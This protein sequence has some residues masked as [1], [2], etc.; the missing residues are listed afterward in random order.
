LESSADGDINLA[1]EEW[2]KLHKAERHSVIIIHNCTSKFLVGHEKCEE[3]CRRNI[4]INDRLGK[5][6][7]N[8][9][10]VLEKDGEDQLDRSCEK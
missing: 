8:N 2:S 7:K 4:I 5:E 9:K 3:N 1:K 10:V 6:R